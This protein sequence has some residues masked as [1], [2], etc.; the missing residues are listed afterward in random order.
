MKVLIPEWGKHT[1]ATLR[2]TE[3]YW[4][5]GKIVVAD[6]WFGSFRNAVAHLSKGTFSI[7]NIKRN[8]AQAPVSILKE[9][10]TVRETHFSKRVR[11][12]L[13]GV[14]D[15]EVYLTIHMDK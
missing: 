10:C 2:L 11:V 15:R 12:K 1:A 6:S 4:H 14:E 3:P 8:N 7:M 9:K 5:Q 13:N